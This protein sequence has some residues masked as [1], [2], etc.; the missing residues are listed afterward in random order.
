MKE[1]AKKQGNPCQL[2]R[3]NA[4][5]PWL[6]KEASK[7]SGTFVYKTIAAATRPAK[8]TAPPTASGRAPG[9]AA[10]NS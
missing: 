7:E 4:V 5:R 6:K 3:K 10:V 9:P 1:K 2:K 8:T